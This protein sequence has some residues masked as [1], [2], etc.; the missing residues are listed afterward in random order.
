MATDSVALTAIP[1]APVL[2]SMCCSSK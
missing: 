1:V 2:E